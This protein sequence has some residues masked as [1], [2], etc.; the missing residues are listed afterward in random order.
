MKARTAR[1]TALAAIGLLTLGACSKSTTKTTDAPAETAAVS[2]GSEVSA[3]P[4]VT[5]AAMASE[6]GG[7]APKA[8]GAGITLAV[9]PWAGSKANANLA[10]IVLEKMGTPVKL[11]EID[12][13]ATWPGL[14]SDQIDAVLEVWPSGHTKDFD[15]YVTQK[16]TVVEIGKLGPKAKIGWYITQAAIDAN[17]KLATW[18]GFKDAAAT[19]PFAT[20]ETGDQGQFL[21]GDPSYVSY[22]EA[23]IKNLNLPL[24][25]TVAGSETALITAIKAADADKKPL[26]VQF[27]QPHWLH[28]KIKMTEVKLP[29]VTD[30]CTASA[31]AKDGKYACDYPVDVLYKAASAKLAAKNPAALKVL[32]ALT[33][34][35]EQQNE[36]SALIDG[37]G[38]DPAVAAKTFLDAHPE[39]EK[40]W[41]A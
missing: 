15:T 16:K 34:T 21:M 20:A 24:K 6:A 19:K 37:E 2:G 38:K 12:E 13:N 41:M 33:L 26:L 30:A 28:S 29:D 9:N 4:A 18:E 25:Y 23:I 32:S 36:I 35:N 22:D 1:L 3:D 40:A 14:D 10:K 7:A 27:W 11:V 8:A 17:P 5:E 39:V 31:T